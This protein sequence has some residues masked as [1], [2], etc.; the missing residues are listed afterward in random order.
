MGVGFRA[1]KN[2]KYD[3]R[4]EDNVNLSDLEISLICPKISK[5]L[6]STY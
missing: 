2:K 5:E 6:A 3:R 1:L 4:E